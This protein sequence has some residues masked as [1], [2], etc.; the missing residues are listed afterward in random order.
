MYVC[1]YVAVCTMAVMNIVF[2]ISAQRKK[3]LLGCRFNKKYET[4]GG[5]NHDHLRNHNLRNDRK[6][7][8]HYL[9][10]TEITGASRSST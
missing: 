10:A 1:G 7:P 4:D 6:Q 5:G 3:V 9:Q 8:A 2:E